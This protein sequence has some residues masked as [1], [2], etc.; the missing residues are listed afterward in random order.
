MQI[1]STT[2]YWGY[3]RRKNGGPSA[4]SR[5]SYGVGSMFN[6]W[7][8]EHSPWTIEHMLWIVEHISWTIK[9]SPL[10]NS[11]QLPPRHQSCCIRGV[12]LSLQGKRCYKDKLW[13]FYT[14]FVVLKTIFYDLSNRPLILSRTIVLQGEKIYCRV[15]FVS[16]SLEESKIIVSVNFIVSPRENVFS[17]TSYVMVSHGDNKSIVK[18]DYMHSLIWK[19]DVFLTTIC[20]MVSWGENS[21]VKWVNVLSRK[22]SFMVMW[23]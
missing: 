4:R 21:L 15:Q 11:E 19:V 16:L 8:V 23:G 13:N 22:I 14:C 9:H 17:M 6:I 20:F 7:I 10:G 3:A 5:S 1:V 2:K 12:N 18:F